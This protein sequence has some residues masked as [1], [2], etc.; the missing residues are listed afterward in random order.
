MFIICVV[1]QVNGPSRKP[2]LMNDVSLNQRCDALLDG[3]C[4]SQEFE[5]CVLEQLYP[6]DF[7]AFVPASGPV[8]LKPLPASFGGQS[9]PS[10]RMTTA[11]GSTVALIAPSAI[12]AHATP[13]DVFGGQRVPPMNMMSLV[14]GEVAT[15]APSVTP[16]AIAAHSAPGNNDG[17]AAALMKDSVIP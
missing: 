3:N 17:Y 10:M 1:E 12:V 7:Q 8:S 4:W 14:G 16:I 6:E 13:A 11:L 9:V 15:V 2:L 5:Q